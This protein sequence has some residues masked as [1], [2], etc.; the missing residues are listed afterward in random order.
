MTVDRVDRL[1]G[2]GGGRFFRRQNR[3]TMV[4]PDVTKRCHKMGQT[5]SQNGTQKCHQNVTK[6]VT[7]RDKNVSQ[8]VTKRVTKT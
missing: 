2:V 7:K 5:V 6:R 1:T 3:T 8:N 4:F